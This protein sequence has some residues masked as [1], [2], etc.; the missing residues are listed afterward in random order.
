MFT[1]CVYNYYNI[2]TFLGC[3]NNN[4]YFNNIIVQYGWMDGWMMMIVIFSLII[5]LLLYSKIF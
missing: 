4:I 3:K 2:L 5:V 1:H